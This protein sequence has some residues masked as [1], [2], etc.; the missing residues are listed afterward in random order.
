M[1]FTIKL[2]PVKQ[3]EDSPLSVSGSDVLYSELATLLRDENVDNEVV[4][5]WIDV[6]DL[7]VYFYYTISDWSLLIDVSDL[8]VYFYY[9]ISD[10]SLLI[11]V[12]DLLVYFYYTISDWG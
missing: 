1:E 12:S 5:D 2:R 8:L 9:T 3:S 11:D 7:I 6:S 10:W 4:I